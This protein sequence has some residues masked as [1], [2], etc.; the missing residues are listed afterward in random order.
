MTPD[1]NAHALQLPWA[2]LLIVGAPLLYVLSAGPVYRFVGKNPFVDALYEPI[3][4]AMQ[5]SDLVF[6][7]VIAYLY[8][9]GVGLV[10]P[11]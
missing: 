8:L 1:G 2:L 3:G 6:H 10:I 5:H 9:W 7:L 11:R 4:W